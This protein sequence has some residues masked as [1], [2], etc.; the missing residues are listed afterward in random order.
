ML[1][2]EREGD[3]SPLYFHEEYMSINIY[4]SLTATMLLAVCY[5]DGFGLDY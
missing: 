4:I 3:E 1:L 5:A 2:R